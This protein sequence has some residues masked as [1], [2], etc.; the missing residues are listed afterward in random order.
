M[1]CAG[2]G[3]IHDPNCQVCH[4]SGSYEY[5]A[6]L[7]YTCSCSIDDPDFTRYEIDGHVFYTPKSYEELH[8]DKP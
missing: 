2:W 6:G 4:G 5:G 1:S 8:P 3:Q 7:W